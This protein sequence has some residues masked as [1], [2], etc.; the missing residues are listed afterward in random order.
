MT[1]SIALI[2]PGK[3]GCAVST[4]LYA[5]G[6]QIK[7]VISRDIKRAKNACDF[8]GCAADLAT[9]D[10]AQAHSAQII[11]LAVPDEAIAATSKALQNVRELSPSQT[12]IHF[13]GLLPARILQH[14]ETT[15]SGIL[16]LHPLLPFADRKQA[17][18]HLVGCPCAVEGN[19]AGL[20]TSEI[21][22]K[23]IPARGFRLDEKAK[24]TY[25][26][27]ASVASNYLITLMEAA[28]QLMDSCEILGYEPLDLLE[29]L[30]RATVDNLFSS[31][32]EQAL[33]GPI[34]RGDISTVA[35]HIQAINESKPE[36]LDF[37]RCLARQTL[38]VAQN[39]GRLNKTGAD[40]LY[41][42]L[43]SNRAGK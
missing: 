3:V 31:T 4:R 37:Y 30:V 23:S 8:I 24:A 7:A 12:L 22:L 19:P 10:L 11:L 9:T 42:L 41:H 39:S 16:A 38:T 21:L 35:G 36:L 40:G 34:V 27:A 25:H 29:P 33:T 17:S 20:Q 6:H 13:S 5:A 26:S 32:P 28:R 1:P 2:G 18:E 15:R 43:Y 14:T